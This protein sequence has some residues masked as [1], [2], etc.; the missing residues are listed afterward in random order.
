M[1]AKLGVLAGGGVLPAAVVAAARSEGRPVFVLAF[2]GYTDPATVMD[3]EHAWVRL[4]DVGD[5]FRILR[6]ASVQEVCLIGHIKRPTLRDLRPDMRCMQMVARLGMRAFGDDG[7]LGG[8]IKEIEGEGFRVV[9]AHEVLRGILAPVGPI[10]RR[11][12]G[13]EDEVDIL[14]GQAVLEA[15]GAVDVGQ[16]IVVERGVVLGIEAIE[17]TDALID[18]CAGLRR[19]TRGGVLVKMAKP[20]QERRVDL[21]TI[22]V[23]TV[24]RVASAG[25]A[26]IVVEAG[27]SLI[28]DRP[29][30]VAAADAAGLFLVGRSRSA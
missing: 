26:G 13:A 6:K 7:L 20:E 14:R 16:A 17:G 19:E 30:V 28:V 9:G 11:Q 12:P 10:G 5:A 2:H 4:G 22:G 29:T 3:V 25:L 21:P 18:R 23:T 24:Q 8:I 15:L 27:R 1:N